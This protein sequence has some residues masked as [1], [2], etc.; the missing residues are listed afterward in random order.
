MSL[1]DDLLTADAAAPRLTCYDEVTGG[2]T[3]LSGATLENWAAKIAN[4]LRTDCGLAP[5]DAI[6]VDLPVIW[7]AGCLLVGAWRAE[8]E[9][10]PV[11]PEDFAAGAAGAGAGTG[12]GA[13]PQWVFTTVEKLDAWE[14]AVPGVEVAVLT[15]DAFGRGVAECGGEVPFGVMDFAPDVRI[16]PDAY[17]GGK[18]NTARSL[19]PGMSEAELAHTVEKQKTSS[20]V[21][22][23]NGARLLSSGWLDADGRF[24]PSAWLAT[25]AAPWAVGGSAVV[26]RA[27]SAPRLAHLADVEKAQLLG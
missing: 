22:L 2:R 21:E 13:A 4:L 9:V 6:A 7:Q 5:G 16:Q 15:D 26:V 17:F 14:E 25:V 1:F 20:E 23:V 10:L 24:S 11:L 12:A 3:E 18:P 27:G 19:V 8:I